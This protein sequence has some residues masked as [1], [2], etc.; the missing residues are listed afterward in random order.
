MCGLLIIDNP[1]DP[2]TLTLYLLQ[3]HLCGP[4]WSQ[5]N[6]TQNSDHWLS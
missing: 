6:T 2:V 5:Y 1:K 4:I 3:N